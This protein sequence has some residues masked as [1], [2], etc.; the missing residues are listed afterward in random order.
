MRA[1]NVFGSVL[2]LFAAEVSAIN[3][4]VDSVGKVYYT[5]ADCPKGSSSK[6]IERPVQKG[7]RPDTL[8]AVTAL[9][10][11]KGRLE[12]ADEVMAG[13]G[14]DFV[15]K[16]IPLYLAT[17]DRI[18]GSSEREAETCLERY[19]ASF[20]DPRSAYVAESGL[21]KNVV[22]RFVYVGVSA[23]NGFGGASRTDLVCSL[24]K[25]QL[26]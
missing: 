11:T 1:S 25:E 20:K 10:T 4:C 3:K 24:P 14:T 26:R 7:G 22:D 23:R 12:T 5:D 13:H 2:L 16:Y 15:Q 9:P 19:R 21:Y 6:E 8:G 18:S 17:A